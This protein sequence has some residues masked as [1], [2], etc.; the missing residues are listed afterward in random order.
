[1]RGVPSQADLGSTL[2]EGGQGHEFPRM[3]G[4]PKTSMKEGEGEDGIESV[5]ERTERQEEKRR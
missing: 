5:G 3:E 4:A 1:M 2:E